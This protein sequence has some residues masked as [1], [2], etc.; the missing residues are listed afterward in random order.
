MTSR[1]M[2]AARC[3]SA[4]GALILAAG[5]SDPAVRVARL[6]LEVPVSSAGATVTTSGNVTT[7]SF[8]MP[9][10]A[11]NRGTESLTFHRC[12]GP[13]IEV[14]D[15]GVWSTA[16]TYAGTCGPETLTTLASGDRVQYELAVTAQ[17][18]SAAGQWRPANVEGTYRLLLRYGR[19]GA[20]Q[21]FV[22]RS[23]TFRL[24]GSRPPTQ[25]R[26]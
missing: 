22:V 9:Y 6:H 19:P 11:E 4:F 10:V 5:C 20:A 8:R 26:E 18:G 2:V 14:L 16:W 3:I 24:T 12:P 25:V 17:T 15:A 23:N 1:T 7:V 21:D 13:A